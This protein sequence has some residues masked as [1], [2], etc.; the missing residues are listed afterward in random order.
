MTVKTVTE[1]AGRI[2][3]LE[4]IKDEY[5]KQKKTQDAKRLTRILKELY[6]VLGVKVA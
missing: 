5:I 3:Y 1:I 2:H 4:R 6:W